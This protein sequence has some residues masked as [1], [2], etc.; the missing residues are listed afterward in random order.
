MSH[1]NNNKLTKHYWVW[2]IACYLVL[3]GLG[4]GI[5]FLAGLFDLIFSPMIGTSIGP[6]FALGVFV[7]VAC[8]GIGSFLLVFELGQPLVFVRVFLSKT[9]IIKWGAVML[10]IALVFGFV[11][12]L[13]FLPPE[14]NLFY[15]G[16]TWIRDICCVLMMIFGIGVVLYTGVLLSSFKAKAFW[17]TPAL[18]VLF[19]VSALSTASAVLAVTAGMW[20]APQA[21]PVPPGFLVPMHE[22][23]EVFVQYMHLIDTVLVL[24]EIVVLLAYVLL[25]YAASNTTSRQMALTWLKGSSAPLFWGGM[26]CFGLLLPFFF[27]VSGGILAE[28]IAPVF[29]LAAGLLLRF[30]VVY[31]DVR[32]PIPGEERFYTRLPKG[33]EKFMPQAGKGH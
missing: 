31:A 13:F 16:W 5:L 22:L 30:M 9:A 17:N 23:A 27:Y 12:F 6:V 21:L 2:P 25:M 28:L 20:P 1:M 24:V 26:I 3:G 18:P 32:R 19:S 4:G 29:V 8:L 11:Y 7:A 10:S 33:D 14:W 15:Y